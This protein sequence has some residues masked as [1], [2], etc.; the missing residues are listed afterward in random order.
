MQR[1]IGATSQLFTLAV[2]E[3]LPTEC[4]DYKYL[5]VGREVWR[6]DFWLALCGVTTARCRREAVTLPPLSLLR[7]RRRGDDQR[8]RAAQ[9]ALA[10]QDASGVLEVLSEAF[11][12]SGGA[13]LTWAQC[14]ASI[15]AYTFAALC[16]ATNRPLDLDVLT[17]LCHLRHYLTYSC[18]DTSL[19]LASL[20]AAL[21]KPACVGALLREAVAR[22]DLLT[23]PSAWTPSDRKVYAEQNELAIEVKDWWFDGAARILAYQAPPS[24][25][26]TASVALL[27]CMLQR[28][29]RLLQDSRPLAVVYACFSAHVRD[30]VEQH[31]AACDVPRAHACRQGRDVQLA[32]S[33]SRPARRLAP[34]R[35]G[36][37]P[38]WGELSEAERPVVLLCDLCSAAVACELFPGAI[39]VYDES[40]QSAGSADAS[41]ALLA[42]APHFVILMSSALQPEAQIRSALAAH[43]LRWPE[44][45]FCTIISRRM[46]RS[47]T[48]R[49]ADGTV[50][51][52][53]YFGSSPEQIAWEPH[54]LRF[55]SARA[56]AALL[57]HGRLSPSL[58]LSPDDVSS[59]RA[60]RSACMRLLRDE[61]FPTSPPSV[62]VGGDW[63][64]LAWQIALE[65]LSEGMVFI[66][67]RDALSCLREGAVLWGSGAVGSALALQ[68][69]G[70]AD[71]ELA[72]AARAGVVLLR[73][74][75]ARRRP[76][77][78]YDS[79]AH[80]EAQRGSPRCV[81]ADDGAIHGVHLAVARIVARDVP[82]SYEAGTHLCG[83]TARCD[84]CDGAEIVFENLE[85]ARAVMQARARTNIGAP[86]KE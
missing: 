30:H 49:L 80:A 81:V 44:A 32:A 29:R 4:C 13:M 31:L 75:D 25:G 11:E 7:C 74:R 33:A 57:L 77:A 26:K 76:M 86:S 46:Q 65:P 53:H 51:V 58:F 72:L 56:L 82:C 14:G 20:Q 69:P 16:W 39:L 17:S 8:R 85:A 34:L 64:L 66:Y 55:Y 63:S 19:A 54:L 67:A 23:R 21:Q 9:S 42:A 59:H 3:I 27:A 40:S 2:P 73:G 22:D 62:T 70:G 50:V 61:V 6:H 15:E 78:V 52:P 24:G 68:C 79:W 38:E 83:R 48:A 12:A 10:L 18:Q 37:Y 47:Y 5:E 35:S 28:M 41:R 45:T 1:A 84:T 36:C 71:E 43:A 60:V